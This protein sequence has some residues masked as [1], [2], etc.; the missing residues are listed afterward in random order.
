MN[1]ILSKVKV[2]LRIVTD[3]FDADITDL[4][5]SC[6]ADLRTCGVVEDDPTDPHIEQAI[7]TYCQANFGDGNLDERKW[8]MERYESQKAHLQMSTGYTDWNK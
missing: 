3:D 7:K 1:T 4:I 5:N 8:L 6:L 2:A